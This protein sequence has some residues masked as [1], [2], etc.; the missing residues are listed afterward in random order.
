MAFAA[1]RLILKDKRRKPS[2][3]EQMN[4]KNKQDTR[5]RSK[6]RS[7]STGSF[8]SNTHQA[9]GKSTDGAHLNAKQHPTREKTPVNQKATPNQKTPN[10]QKNALNKKEAQKTPVKNVPTAQKGQNKGG[11]P[12][13]SPPL[14]KLPAPVTP[15]PPPAPKPAPIKNPKKK[16]T[17]T[18]LVVTINLVSTKHYLLITTYQP[19]E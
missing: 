8:R 9:R 18:E 1:A 11:K 4:Q 19:N 16:H 12:A 7:A 13:T 3:E 6:A 14:Q 5:S 15:A 17:P 2:K 10:N